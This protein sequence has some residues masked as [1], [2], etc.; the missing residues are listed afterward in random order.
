M[1]SPFL[2]ATADDMSAQTEKTKVL[3]YLEACCKVLTTTNEPLA[4]II[5]YIPD[6]FQG[7]AEMVLY[8]LPKLSRVNFVADIS[9]ENSITFFGRKQRR[10]SKILL[11]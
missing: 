3:H 1:Q 6:N 4:N 11:I 8:R 7:V 9:K 5:D 2:H 10:T